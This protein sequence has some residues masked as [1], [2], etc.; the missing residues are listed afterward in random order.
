MVYAIAIVALVLCALTVWLLFRRQ[1]GSAARSGPTAR[2]QRRG[3]PPTDSSKAGTYHSVTINYSRS[4]PCDAVR[5][6]G[7]NI[8]LADTAPSLPLDD[9]TSTRCRCQYEHHEDR[10]QDERRRFHHLEMGFLESMGIQ[11]RRKLPD[12]RADVAGWDDLS[13]H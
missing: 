1:R 3:R 5:Q 11:D 10:R 9:C 4:D 13:I 8:Y 12:R 7:G 6:V 2:A